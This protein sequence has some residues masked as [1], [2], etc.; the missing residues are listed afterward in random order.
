MRSLG[1]VCASACLLISVS[2]AGH[3]AQPLKFHVSGIPDSVL[4]A[5]ATARQAQDGTPTAAPTDET[6]RVAAAARKRAPASSAP[7]REATIPPDDRLAIQVELAW[8]GDYRGLIN[9]ETDEKTAAA[10]LVPEEPKIQG[11][12][13]SQHAGA[14]V[15]LCL[16]QSQAGSGRLDHGR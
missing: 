1:A 9:G 10:V 15:A 13:S 11:D 3:V 14:R 12:R 2:A 8:T 16:R 5:H 6:I 4:R 7:K